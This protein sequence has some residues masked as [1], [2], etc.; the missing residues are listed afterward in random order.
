VVDR[1]ERSP[2]RRRRA[3]KAGPATPNA[4]TV[5]PSFAGRSTRAS[6]IERDALPSISGPP[7]DAHDASSADR[8]QAER[9]PIPR[10][11]SRAIA[12]EDVDV[13]DAIEVELEARRSLSM[14]ASRPSG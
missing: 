12:D 8:G 9:L 6:W 2:E 10:L 5:R 7:F 1:I 4:T 3:S 13:V 11:R 14:W